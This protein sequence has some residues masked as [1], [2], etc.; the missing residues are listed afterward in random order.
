[1]DGTTNFIHDFPFYSISI[2]CFYK[3]TI[4][5]GLIYDLSRDDEYYASKGKG[6][7]CNKTRIRVSGIKGLKNSLIC[8]SFHGGPDLEPKF[9]QLTLIRNLYSNSLTLRRTGSTALDLAFVASGKLDAFLGYGM[10]IWDFAA[11][12]LLVREAGGFI[13][14]FNGEEDVFSSHSIVAG[15]MACV[16]AVNKEIKKSFV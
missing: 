7:F 16:K 12:A 8:N 3:G 1:M 4:E 13:N 9:D 5:H 10:K 11:G 6:A 2:A 15:N 14:D